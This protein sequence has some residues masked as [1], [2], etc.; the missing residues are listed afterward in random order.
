M[1]TTPCTAALKMMSRPA[2]TPAS[3]AFWWS[4]TDD[5]SLYQLLEETDDASTPNIKRYHVWTPNGY[6]DDLLLTH[7]STGSN[8]DDYF[9][10]RDRQYNVVALLDASGGVIERYDYNPYGQRLVLD[11]DYS[12]DPDGLSDVA[13]PIGHQGLYHD[14]ESGLVYN[15]ARYRDPE[16]GRWLEKDPFKYRDGMNCYAYAQAKPLAKRDATGLSVVVAVSTNI[17]S[18][19]YNILYDPAKTMFGRDRFENVDYT[20]K[21]SHYIN[22]KIAGKTGPSMATWRTLS[23]AFI[24]I[25]R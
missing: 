6:V 7:D 12:D 13:N 18:S 10:C 20:V 5:P 1:L 2:P 16:L 11:P 23:L 8:D 25:S 3:P 24:Y 17:E 19:Y 22:L 14:D 21:T 9:V 15:R 4:P